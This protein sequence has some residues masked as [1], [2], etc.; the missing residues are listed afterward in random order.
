MV[1]KRLKV[2]VLLS[3]SGTTL[4]NLI[5][6]MEAGEL[7]IEIILVISSQNDAYGIERAKKHNIPA[8]VFP[9]KEYPSWEKFNQAVSDAVIEVNPDLIVLAGY[10][11]LFRTDPKY[12]GRIMNIHPALIPS[13]CGKGVFGHHVHEAVI[14]M[15]VKISGTTVHFVDEN[16]DTGPIILQKAVEVYDE[17]TPESLAERVQ[18]AEREIYPR[19]IRLFHENR[20]RVEGRRVKILPPTE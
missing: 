12:Y 7:P 3:G 4:Q 11:S 19:A 14:E 9:R 10:M 6:L 1:K 16:Y 13:F 15:G 17:D 5:D 18:A 8:R 20:L 2:A